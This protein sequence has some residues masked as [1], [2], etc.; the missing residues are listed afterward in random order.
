MKDI[1]GQPI[2][3]CPFATRT[4]VGRLETM[5]VWEDT[6]CQRVPLESDG[7]NEHHRPQ[8]SVS[9]ASLARQRLVSG[10]KRNALLFSKASSKQGP[11][12]RT[13]IC[14]NRRKHAQTGKV[15]NSLQ[16]L[17]GGSC[18]FFQTLWANVRLQQFS[19]MHFFT[20]V[21]KLDLTYYYRQHCYGCCTAS[22]SFSM[23]DGT[24]SK[25]AKHHVSPSGKRF[26]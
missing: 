3:S 22:V 11:D 12:R 18:S 1:G 13:G 24:C 25:D 16:R 14:G 9:A 23:L 7:L 21:F 2:R 15:Q 17:T 10:C 19:W 26:F 6:K 5:L 8:P 20:S 4:T